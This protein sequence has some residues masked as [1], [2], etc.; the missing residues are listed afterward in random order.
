MEGCLYGMLLE[1][2]LY[3]HTASRCVRL[4]IREGKAGGDTVRVPKRK[5]TTPGWLCSVCT[6]IPRL[7]AH[8]PI[9]SHAL[10][11]RQPQP[12]E[13]EVGAHPRAL[14]DTH[15]VDSRRVIRSAWNLCL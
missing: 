4:E 8:L 10:Q 1:L 2:G 14:R 11:D 13:L 5:Q 15:T 7:S 9:H 3:G 6:Q 12:P